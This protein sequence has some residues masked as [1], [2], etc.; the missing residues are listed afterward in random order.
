M[1]FTDNGTCFV[2]GKENPSGLRLDFSISDGHASATYLPDKAHQGYRNI[3]H[4]GLIS[5]L[6]DEAAVKAASSLGIKAI[7]VEICVRFKTPL[8]IGERCIVEASVRL[9]RGRLLKGVAMVK[10]MDGTI[11]AEG[12]LKLFRT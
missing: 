5:T 2:C 8:M 4:G 10:K 9:V 11:V 12:H 3:L 7:T 1:E 6:I